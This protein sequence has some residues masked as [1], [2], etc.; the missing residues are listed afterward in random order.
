MPPVSLEYKVTRTGEAFVRLSVYLPPDLSVKDKTAVYDYL[1]A[2]LMEL[3][4]LEMA[5]Q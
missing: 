2:H 5:I 1:I 4:D 3:R